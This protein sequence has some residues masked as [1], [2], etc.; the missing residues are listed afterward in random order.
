V[1]TSF[2]SRVI[3]GGAALALTAC[4]MSISFDGGR[5]TEP[6][7][8]GFPE[9]QADAYDFVGESTLAALGLQAAVP[10]P[11]P[12][13]DRV[14]M[15]WVTHDPT[16][17]DPGEPGG[18]AVLTRMLCFEFPDGSGGSGWPVDSSWQPPGSAT[19]VARGDLGALALGA[20]ALGALVLIG[21]SVMAFRREHHPP[22]A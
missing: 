7:P 16:L 4:G 22:E 17:H 5:T 2:W 20:L 6:G 19:G 9:C 15:I 11:L 10:A 1:E 12:D 3:A 18:E 13:V 21:A 14:A 8:V